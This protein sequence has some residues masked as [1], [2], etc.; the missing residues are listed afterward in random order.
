MPTI[1]FHY[2]TNDLTIHNVD[3]IGV[4]MPAGFVWIEDSPDFG[5]PDVIARLLNSDELPHNITVY[6]GKY[7]HVVRLSDCTGVTFESQQS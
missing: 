2:S 6:A 7:R 1:V 3:K 5:W 4:D